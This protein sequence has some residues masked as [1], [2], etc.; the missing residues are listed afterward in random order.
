MYKVIGGDQKEYGPVSAE[1]LRQWIA[2]GRAGAQTKAQSEGSAEWQPLSA[3]PEFND[4]L[5]AQVGAP[6]AFTT[7]QAE[8]ARSAALQQ[9]KAPATWLMV[10]GILGVVMS[11]LGLIIHVLAMA[12]FEF[13]SPARMPDPQLQALLNTLGGPIGIVSDILG[14]GMSSIVIWGSVKM[15][16]LQSHPFAVGVSILAMVPCFSPC[17]LVGLP[18]G[19]W[20]LVVLNR[21]EVK[22]QFD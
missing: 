4:A 19:I 7:H 17:C 3:F 5:T 11:V 20:A 16:R 2:E 8:G 1:Q 21:P 12:G 9:V 6:A 15:R 14:I 10:V 13:L 22:S 18:A